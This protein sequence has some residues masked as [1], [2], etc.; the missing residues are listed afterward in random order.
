MSESKSPMAAR[1]PIKDASKHADPIPL[2][3]RAKTSRAAAVK[4]FCLDC[5][6]GQRMEVRNCTSHD[7]A[8]YPHRPYQV[9]REV[10]P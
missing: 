7:C 4:L 10:K 2:R 3:I 5:V 9:A 1:F 6:G 8:L